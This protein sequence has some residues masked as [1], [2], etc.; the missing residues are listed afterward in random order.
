MI[1]KEIILNLLMSDIED[2][3][4]G[5]KNWRC[6]IPQLIL[7]VNYRYEELPCGWF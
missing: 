5:R 2:N 4:N 1:D 7:W 6:Y 3:K